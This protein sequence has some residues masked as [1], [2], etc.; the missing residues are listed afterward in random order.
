MKEISLHI[1]DI[2]QNSIAAGATC[3]RL[4]VV[5]STSQ[6]TLEITIQDNGCGIEPELLRG[7]VDPFT[8]TRTTRRV[9]MGLPMF[10]ASAQQAGGGLSVTSQVG[11][12]TCVTARYQL[13][14]I[15]CPVLG[16]LAS[17]VQ[18]QMVANPQ[19]RLIFT[20]TTDHGQCSVDTQQ[21]NQIL[22]EV[23]LN[24]PAV[25][26]WL[27]EYLNDAIQSVNGGM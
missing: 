26:Q 1:L 20:Y 8:T 24:T 9:G 13:S 2:M 19:I 15:D 10:H 22:G 17:T 5:Q 12:G 27:K 6:D 21:I 25:A 7:I 3:I 11:R 16:D 14:H 18:L 4:H 23:P